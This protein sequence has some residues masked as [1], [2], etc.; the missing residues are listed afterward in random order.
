MADQTSQQALLHAAG[1]AGA[2]AVVLT[3]GAHRR[4]LR[5]SEPG[6]SADR[7]A[8][9]AVISGLEAL[10]R[11]TSV[12]VRVHNDYVRRGGD[13]ELR[14]R[15]KAA[16]G[17][18]RVTWRWSGE[19]EELTQAQALVVPREDPVETARKGQLADLALAIAAIEKAPP[20]ANAVPVRVKNAPQAEPIEQ[21]PAPV[22]AG[23][24]GTFVEA[25]GEHIADDPEAPDPAELVEL[26]EKMVEDEPR[27]I[28]AVGK[29]EVTFEG[30][31]AVAVPAEIAGLAQVGWRVLL[32]AAFVEG[33]WY[34]LDVAPGEA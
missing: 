8:I 32:S 18:H 28:T 21:A 19:Y 14:E 29:G 20:S 26:A 9:T 23:S 27:A 17:R 7:M 12:E 22:K 6:A 10:T 11:P 1:G 16:A 34:L 30:I 13:G 31:G 2:W 25:L 3:F 4:E 15:F 33:N 24:M 5:G